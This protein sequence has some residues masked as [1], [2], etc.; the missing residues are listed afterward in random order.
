VRYILTFVNFYLFILYFISYAI[1]MLKSHF[2]SCSLVYYIFLCTFLLLIYIH[3][4]DEQ[5]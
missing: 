3:L 5:A 4:Y 2:N 1:S